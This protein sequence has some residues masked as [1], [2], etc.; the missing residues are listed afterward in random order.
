M[1]AL[2]ELGFTAN[3]LVMES[4]LN[5]AWTRAVWYG[6]HQM[7]FNFPKTHVTTLIPVS[8]VAYCTG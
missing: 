5:K 1:S 4:M 8:V 2:R 6:Y 3:F 7:P